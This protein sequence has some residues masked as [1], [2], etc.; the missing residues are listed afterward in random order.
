[1]IAVVGA[2]WLHAVGDACHGGAHEGSTACCEAEHR[3]FETVID[4]REGVLLVGAE[5]AAFCVVVRSVDQCFAVV[6]HE[7][8][9]GDEGHSGDEFLLDATQA[10]GVEGFHGEGF[11]NGFVEFLN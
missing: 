7:S 8:G 5:T 9:E 1:M 10:L 4:D 2:I 6:G 3:F 11:L